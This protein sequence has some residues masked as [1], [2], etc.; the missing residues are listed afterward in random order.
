MGDMPPHPLPNLTY[1]SVD[2]EE[3]L[4]SSHPSMPEVVGRTDFYVIRVEE[5]PLP[6][7]S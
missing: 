5:L 6:L 1:G 7:T 4:L 3:T 2:M